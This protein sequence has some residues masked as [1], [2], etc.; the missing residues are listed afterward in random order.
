MDLASTL[1]YLFGEKGNQTYEKQDLVST[2][3]LSLLKKGVL[4]C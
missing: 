2:N 4:K 3:H 1:L